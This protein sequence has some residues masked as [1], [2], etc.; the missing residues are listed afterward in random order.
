MKSKS[1]FTT[2]ILKLILLYIIFIIIGYISYRL[3]VSYGGRNTEIFQNLSIIIA[4]LGPIY[5]ILIKNMIQALISENVADTSERNRILTLFVSLLKP[6]D[7]ITDVQVLYH[8][9]KTI[10]KQKNCNKKID[11]FSIFLGNAIFLELILLFSFIGIWGAELPGNLSEIMLLLI[12]FSVIIYFIIPI[13]FNTVSYKKKQ[14]RQEKAKTEKLKEESKEGKITLF[15]TDIARKK[16][17]MKMPKIIFITTTFIIPLISLV[18]MF[19]LPRSIYYGNILGFLIGLGIFLFLPGLIIAGGY[20]LSC[21]GASSTQQVVYQDGKL[22]YKTYTGSL[23]QRVYKTYTVETIEHYEVTK[24]N[25]KIYGEIK[26]KEKINNSTYD[27]ILP[28]KK[29]NIVRI[30]QNEDELLEII[31]DYKKDVH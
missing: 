30:C 29:L 26:G 16:E 12:M 3:S 7:D 2:K 4:I 17:Y 25:I 5:V 9:N 27:M 20:C 18:L 19:A 6:I 31:K 14:T 13:L 21:S 10:S 8:G 15:E 11:R 22:I 1:K 23:D 28:I 24:R